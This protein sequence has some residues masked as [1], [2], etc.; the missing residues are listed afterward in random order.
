MLKWIWAFTRRIPIASGLSDHAHGVVLTGRIM[1]R[2]TECAWNIGWT[3]SFMVTL[4]GVQWGWTN[5]VREIGS[6]IPGRVKLMT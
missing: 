5:P 1:G 4:Y 6:L 2:M 3:S